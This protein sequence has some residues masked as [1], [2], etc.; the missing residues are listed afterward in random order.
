MSLYLPQQV[1]HIQAF[2]PW[3]VYKLHTIFPQKSYPA[4]YFSPPVADSP[5]QSCFLVV[6]RGKDSKTK[7]GAQGAQRAQRAQR[8]QMA[9]GVED[10][11]MFI[12]FDVDTKQVELFGV[13]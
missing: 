7:Y 3:D 12:K 9:K 13:K 6:L 4:L 11:R 2:P 8:A 1:F 5:A 10:I